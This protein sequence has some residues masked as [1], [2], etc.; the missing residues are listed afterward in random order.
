MHGNTLRPIKTLFYLERIA[1][2]EE[3]LYRDSEGHEDAACESNISERI[4]HVRE[5]E[6]EDVTSNFKG[7]SN[8]NEVVQPSKQAKSYLKE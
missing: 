7:S 2:T 8:I 5:E 4:D 3:S 6:S 1:D